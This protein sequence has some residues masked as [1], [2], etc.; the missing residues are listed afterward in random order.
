M[1]YDMGRNDAGDLLG[2]VIYDL[3]D[4]QK[5]VTVFA[6]RGAFA[7][8]PEGPRLVLVNG[9]RQQRDKSNGHLSVL[10]LRAIHARP[11]GPWRGRRPARPSARRAAHDRA[12]LP[13]A[14][15]GGRRLGARLLRRAQHAP[16]RAARRAGD[17]AAADP[18]P[19]ARRVQP[20]RPDP[21]RAARHGLGLRLRVR[22]YRSQGPVGPRR[23]GD[24][25]ALSQPCWRR[26]PPPRG[27]CGATRAAPAASRRWPEAPHVARERRSS[28]TSPASSC[29]G[30]AASSL[31]MLSDRLPA[32]LH[33]ADP[34]RRRRG[35]TRRSLVLLEMALLKQPYMAQ[36]IMPFV[37]LFGTM[38]AFWRLTRSNE[39]VVARAAGRFGVAVPGAAPDGGL[40]RR[41]AD[42]HRLQ[43]DRLGDAGELRA[44][45]RPHPA[46]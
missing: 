32:R 14:A 18:V 1:V 28:A 21:A 26:S 6:E 23:R 41:R 12:V 34:P 3:R 22:R 43:S 5:P 27:S 44:A 40:S 15:A 13:R 35:P 10:T 9:T 30:A 42:G 17:G 20:A 19:A 4:P 46:Q 38:M 8:T 36:Q 25:A 37:V 24:P 2:L 7:D 16:R 45:R 33:R 11:R 29:C 39:L 31:A